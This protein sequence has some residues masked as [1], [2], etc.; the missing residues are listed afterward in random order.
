MKDIFTSVK[1]GGHLVIA[2]SSRIMVPFKV[3]LDLCLAHPV[4]VHPYH[5]SA[6]SYVYSDI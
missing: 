3:P 4:D 2:E 5:F 6:H 1:P